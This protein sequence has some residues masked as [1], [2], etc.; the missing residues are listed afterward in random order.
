MDDTKPIDHTS[1][2]FDMDDSLQ[3]AE[4]P[5]LGT[6]RGLQFGVPDLVTYHQ[7]ADAELQ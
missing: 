4:L 7:I 3:E 6:T 2:P 5:T 1:I